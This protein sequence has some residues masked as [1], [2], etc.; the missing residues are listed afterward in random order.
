MIFCNLGSGSRGNSSFVKSFTTAV[1]VDQ[2][3]SIRQLVYRMSLRGIDPREVKAIILTHEHTDHVSGVAPFARRYRLPVYMTGKTF[4][5]INQKKFYK[6]E[7]VTFQSGDTI[8]I[9]DI[10]VRTFHIPHDA[11]DPVGL[12]MS[13]NGKSIGVLTDIGSPIESLLYHIRD[14]NLLLLES[15]H[16]VFMLL[17]GPYPLNVIRRIKSRMGHLSNDQAVSFFSRIRDSRSLEY[18]VLGHLSET[19]NDPSLVRKLFEEANRNNKIKIEIASQDLPT[20]LIE[21]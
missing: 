11:A 20:A 15:N 21:L 18:L 1:L 7:V 9:G 5:A 2:G 14:V 4:E 10:L 12:V 16:D 8:R 6:V 17:N 13:S 19:N 3:F